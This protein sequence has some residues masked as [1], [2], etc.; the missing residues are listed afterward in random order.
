MNKDLLE[1]FDNDYPGRAYT[2]TITNPEFTSVCPRSGLPDFGTIT[3]TY[4]PDRTCLELKALKYYFLEYR[5]QGVFYEMAVNRILDDLVAA[6]DPV[7]MEVVGEFNTRGGMRSV[8]KATYQREKSRDATTAE[9][10]A[11]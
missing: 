1:V 3:V 10:Q 9:S 4:V 8:V 7:R 5:N 11:T 6:C 2:I